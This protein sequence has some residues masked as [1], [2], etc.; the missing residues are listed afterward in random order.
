VPDGSKGENGWG[1]DKIPDN[2]PRLVI[3][4]GGKVP[5][6]PRNANPMW[7]LHFF[8]HLKEGGTAGFVMATGELSN[9]E[10]ARLQVRKALVEQDCVDC[11]VQLTG[12]LFA[13]TQIPCALWFLSKSRAG[14]NGFRPR[15]G[16]ILFIDGRKLGAL[17]PGSR[18][19]KQLT[20]DEIEKVAAV[21]RQF[22]RQGVPDEVPGFCRV[23]EVREH[24]YALTSGRYVGSPDDE[25]GDEPFEAKMP[26]LAAE[27][28]KMLTEAN[29]LEQQILVTLKDY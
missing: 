25:E 3:G 29:E 13:N 16:E 2:D 22:R 19:Q 18:K 6:S 7:M 15:K 1:A 10:T 24:N 4:M 26:R 11:I 5:L 21:Y 23:D 28:R 14:G 12:Q 20:D 9:S 17:M 8:Y 27:L